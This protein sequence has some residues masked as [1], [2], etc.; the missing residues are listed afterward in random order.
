MKKFLKFIV[1]FLGVL[2][3]ILLSVTILTIFNKYKN[4]DIQITEILKLNPS[5]EEKFDVRSFQINKNQIHL[6]LENK[7]D[8]SQ[9]I[10]TYDT[11]PGTLSNELYLNDL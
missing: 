9:L 10:K 5:I 11:K 3:I 4:Q 1:I 2:I 8:N 7:V 6:H